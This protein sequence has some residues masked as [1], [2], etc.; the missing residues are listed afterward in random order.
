MTLMRFD[1]QV[2]IITG[3]GRGI[4]RSYARLLA[5]RGARVVVNDLGGA[6]D[7]GGRD[8]TVAQRA[9]EGITAEGGTAVA[10]TADVAAPGGAEAM[11][12]TALERFGRLDGLIANAGTLRYAPLFESTNDSLRRSLEVHVIGQLNVCRAAWQQLLERGYGRIVLTGSAGMFGLPELLDYNIAKAAVLG[13]LNSLALAGEPVGIMVNAIAPQASTRMG[14]P[15]DRPEDEWRAAEALQRGVPEHIA[16]LGAVLLH[17]TCPVNGAICSAGG[18]GV[19]L[20]S[21][22]ETRGISVSDLEPEDI[23]ERWEEIADP[24]DAWT[25]LGLE[26]YMAKFRELHPVL[27]PAS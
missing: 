23:L 25:P 16:P 24:A 11:V 26:G 21:F 12:T 8:P 2:F 5:S 18:G 14:A 10:D 17:R 7:G 20:I 6:V 13:L 22:R 27:P 3:A 1:D 9:V 4:G 19:G 15:A